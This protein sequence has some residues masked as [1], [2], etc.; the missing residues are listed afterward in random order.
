MF[1]GME[2]VK[3]LESQGQLLLLKDSRRYQQAG[4][5]AKKL[6][7]FVY[8]Y[9]GELKEINELKVK[10]DSAYIAVDLD[11]FERVFED[12]KKVIRKLF[13]VKKELKARRKLRVFG[14]HQDLMANALKKIRVL[15]G[16]VSNGERWI[17]NTRMTPK[18]R[19]AAMNASIRMS[20]MWG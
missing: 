10:L 20:A 6:F 3:D 12:Y 14:I 2:L 7:A 5:T 11:S 19:E 4:L 16:V 13:V 17:K 15:E 1:N 18:Q 8:A 9:E